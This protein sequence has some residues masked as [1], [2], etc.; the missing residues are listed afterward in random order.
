MQTTQAQPINHSKGDAFKKPSLV[1]TVSMRVTFW[2][3]AAPL[4]VRHHHS[5]R[6]RCGEHCI[7]P[8]LSSTQPPTT[9]GSTT[10]GL[11]NC[12]CSSPGCCSTAR[13]TRHEFQNRTCSNVSPNLSKA[14]GK[15]FSSPPAQHQAKA[16]SAL[17]HQQ[18]TSQPTQL[19][20]LGELSRARQALQGN[21][22]TFR[23]LTNPTARPQHPPHPLAIDIL[24][25]TPATP[26]H[27][28]QQLIPHNLASA[29]KG[30]SPG[31]S[32]LTA[33]IAKVLLD[34][35]AAA[36]TFHRACHRLANATIPNFHS[37][38]HRHG[39]AHS[40]SKA[41]RRSAGLGRRR[42]LAATGGPQRSTTLRPRLRCQVP[43][44]PVRVVHTSRHRS[45]HTQPAANDQV[46]PSFRLTGSVHTTMSAALPC[47]KGS[48]THPMPKQRYLSSANSTASPP[49]ICG[50][51]TP[52]K[53]TA[54]QA[55]GG[56]QGDPPDACTFLFGAGLRPAG[57]PKR[58]ASRRKSSSI[59]R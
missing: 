6:D 20:R 39:P 1:S 16:H 25:F 36:E 22:D 40:P 3:S 13:P 58:L 38:G 11:G 33:E 19:T 34:D 29:R 10:K 47:C 48:S 7:S 30:T 46:K 55:D 24:T 17:H 18:A 53:C 52:A 26:L 56:E 12:G 31:P 21:D 32:G 14:L 27:L 15:T 44:L 37:S 42:L 50:R 9:I 49:H 45:T 28:P 51:T 59:L 41:S 43:H 35:P 5:F 8:W 2:N 23:A 57:L 54:S 4:S